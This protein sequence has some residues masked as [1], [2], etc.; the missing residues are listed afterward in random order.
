MENLQV[1]T[2]VKGFLPVYHKNKENVITFLRH[3]EDKIECRNGE[4]VIIDIYENGKLIFSGDKY[5]FF[6]KLKS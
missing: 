2:T 3:D 6:S 4:L 5:E 1:R